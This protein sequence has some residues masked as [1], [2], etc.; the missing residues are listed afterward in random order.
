[1]NLM[2][3][4]R[5]GVT[6]ELNLMLTPREGVTLELNLMLTPSEEVL[7]EM[8]ILQAKL[9]HLP[10]PNEAAISRWS[11]YLWMAAIKG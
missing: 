2:L 10:L 6:L 8:T 3:T 11:A 9:S 1:M 4:P 7:F 5:E